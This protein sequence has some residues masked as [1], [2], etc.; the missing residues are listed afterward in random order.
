LV[1]DSKGVKFA[2]KEV[3]KDDF[4]E[5]EWE[6][7]CKLRKFFF[8]IVFIFLF[9]K[10]QYVVQLYS[11]FIIENYIYILMEF[12]NSG[13][14][15]DIMKEEPIEENIVSSIMFQISLIIIKNVLY[16]F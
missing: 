9:S 8:F 1:S 4:E 12:V 10:T 16:V 5:R 14:L 7:A 11:R 3:P 6:S 15:T 13:C 2:L